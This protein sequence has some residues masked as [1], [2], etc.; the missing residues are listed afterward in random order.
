MRKFRNY[1][2]YPFT[3]TGNANKK[4]C[5]NN[6][7]THKNQFFEKFRTNKTRANAKVTFSHRPKMQVSYKIVH[8]MSN[9]I[10]VLLPNKYIQVFTFKTKKTFMKKRYFLE[11]FTYSGYNIN[12]YRI[13][14]IKIK[15]I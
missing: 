11:H 12:S 10:H 5:Y 14:I 1:K 8:C 15:K 4:V 9:Y 6:L 7:N 3:I 13:L 2:I